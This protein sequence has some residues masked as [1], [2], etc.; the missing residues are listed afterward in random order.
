EA[1]LIEGLRHI[2]PRAAVIPF[3]STV[4][5]SALAGP[6]VDAR[7]WYRNVRQPVLFYDTIMKL[8]EAGHRTFLELGAHPILRRDIGRGLTRKST[9]GATLCSLRRD[10]RERAALLGSLGRLYTLGADID[11]H[12]LHPA[13]A[14]AIKLPAY[15]FQ[16]EVHWRESDITR[17]IRLG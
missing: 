15:P 11:S 4:T 10:D 5:G 17:R 13:D 12:K 3:F 8:I 2:R 9:G 6:E 14:T 16:A 1:E 7:Y